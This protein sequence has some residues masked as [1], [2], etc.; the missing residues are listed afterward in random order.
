MKN[1]ILFGFLAFLFS[2]SPRPQVQ[3]VVVYDDNGVETLVDL[4]VW[5][6]MQ[7]SGQTM[8][9]QNYYYYQQQQVQQAPQSQPEQVSDQQVQPQP[10]KTKAVVAPKAPTS[11]GF[12]KVEIKTP[13][14]PKAPTSVGFQKVTTPP[15]VT[16]KRPT[17]TGFSKPTPAPVKPAVTSKSPTSTGFKKQ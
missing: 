14:K 9:Q 10:S 8:T 6:A 16:D 12:Q 5:Q 15:V 1:L 4:A 17:S 2:C 11:I 13:E 7:R 3:H